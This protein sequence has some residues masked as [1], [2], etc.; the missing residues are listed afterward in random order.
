MNESG[1]LSSFSGIQD[2]ILYA[3]INFFTYVTYSAHLKLLDLTASKSE[4]RRTNCKAP[5]YVVSSILS[6]LT[7]P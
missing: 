3:L 2:K 7:F 5:H 6:L 1:V 4:V